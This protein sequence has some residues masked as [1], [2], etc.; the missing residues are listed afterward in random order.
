GMLRPG[1]PGAQI[2]TPTTPP[3]KSTTISDEAP[4]EVTQA[5]LPL[6]EDLR[7]D[8]T[9]YKY[10]PKTGERVWLRKGNN[11]V[12]CMPRAADG[13]TRCSNRSTAARRDFA[14][15]LKAQ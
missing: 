13:F 4:D 2:M 11:F 14:A 7:A 5:T 8:A 6:P 15:K 3:V 12:E 1:P 9:V 10:D